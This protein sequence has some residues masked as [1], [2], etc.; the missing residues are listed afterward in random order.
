LYLFFNPINFY[1]SLCFLSIILL[2]L[3]NGI[4]P[5]FFDLCCEEAYYQ[6]FL[7]YGLVRKETI[8][9]AR[10]VYEK[11]PILK[12]NNDSLE[13]LYRVGFEVGHSILEIFWKPNMFLQKE[14]DFY[15]NNY[16]KSNFV[17][18]IQLRYKQVCFYFNF[19]KNRD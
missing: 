12:S 10:K 9:S 17:I 8:K 16:F 7:D 3:F 6:L 11:T 4:G 5:L 18:G 15:Y 13:K 19:F 14:V 2:K 1:L